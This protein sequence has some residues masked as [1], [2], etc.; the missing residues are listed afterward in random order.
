M[1]GEKCPNPARFAPYWHPRE[2]ILPSVYPTLPFPSLG[3]LSAFLP[4]SIAL[5]SRAATHAETGSHPCHDLGFQAAETGQHRGLPWLT[6]QRL[7]L[8]T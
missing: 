1:P 2:L 8:Q 5:G 6:P 3:K 7:P 4:G